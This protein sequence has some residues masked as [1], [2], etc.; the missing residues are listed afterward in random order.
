MPPGFEVGGTLLALSTPVATSAPPSE[1]CV[2]GFLEQLWAIARTTF[3]ES[4]RQPVLLVVLTAGTIFVV[5]SN[6]FSGYTLEDDQ[7][8]FIDLGLSTIFICG[9]V[10]AAFLATSVLNREIENRTAL[11]V[12]SKPV[13][14]PT[15]ILGKY[16]GVSGALLAAV[17]FLGL[18]FLLVEVHG[19]MQTVR[20]P[21]HL[22]A[23]TFGISALVL[24]VAVAA[25]ANFLY[26]WAFTS[27][28]VL[29][30]LPLLLLAYVLTLLFAHDWAP[31]AIGTEFEPQILLAI[32]GMAMALLMLVAVA[33]AASTRLGQL[34][35]LAITM[36]LFLIGL[37]SDWLFGRTI[38]R[39]EE[40]FASAPEAE[41]SLF[42]GAHLLYAACR[43][44]YAVVPDFQVFWLADALTQK[45]EIPFSYFAA[46][47]PYGVLMIAASLAIATLLFQRREVS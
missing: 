25:A 12:L 39:L 40:A 42:D 17:A 26:G 16:V 21:Y 5:L 45:R 46:V 1:P 24:A 41:R 28:A 20:T 6:P 7:R 30:G 34:P 22:P 47:L 29:L 44:A 2:I 36:G 14:R 35:T 31:Q 9:V 23:L 4:I 27:T 43:V 37:L 11:T 8:L 10:L 32:G 19:T 18:A 38:L 3:A 15:F 33:I 13:S